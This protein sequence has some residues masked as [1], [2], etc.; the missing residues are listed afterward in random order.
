MKYKLTLS[1]LFITIISFGQNLE[2]ENLW[3]TKGVYDS[4]GNFLEHSKIQSFLYISKPNQIHRLRT[5]DKINM[6]TGKMKV[7]V[8][9][10]T[11]DLEP[12]KDLSFKINDDETLIIHSKDS[13]TI[14]YKN[15][16]TSYV[17]LSIPKK[18][19]L[20]KKVE[21]VLFDNKMNET[22]EGK[23][24]YNL[25]YHKKGLVKI[26]PIESESGWASD[27]ELINFNGYILIQGIVSAPK[28][29]VGLRRKEIQFI[30][31]DYRFENKNG[32]LKKIR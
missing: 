27:Y 25:I 20:S 32:T 3:R 11:I 14:K 12:L 6:E 30:Q 4:L 22:I 18:K 1:L 23:N 15:F 2:T 10:D 21:K 26:I 28:L 19:L 9:K 24:D 7:F 16:N 29:I 31:I 13:L 17:K 8:Y 5:Q